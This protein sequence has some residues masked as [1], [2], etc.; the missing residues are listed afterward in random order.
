MH[1][2][3]KF[4]VRVL[5]ILSLIC[6]LMSWLGFSVSALANPSTHS[7]TDNADPPAFLALDLVQST[8]GSTWDPVAGDLGSGYA[9]ALCPTTEYHYL[10]T[11][12][13]STN[14]ELLSGL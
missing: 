11:G 1:D 10:D 4:F 9:M 6:S 14:N 5:V 2:P 7:L 13:V 3:H 12:Y 8:D